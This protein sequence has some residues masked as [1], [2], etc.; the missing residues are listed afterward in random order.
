M[1]ISLNGRVYRVV[2]LADTRVVIVRTRAGRY[3]MASPHVAR[4][5]LSGLTLAVF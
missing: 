3:R 5:I 4:M 1:T 2:R